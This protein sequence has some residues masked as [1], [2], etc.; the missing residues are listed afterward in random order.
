MYNALL[1]ATNCLGGDASTQLTCL[2][3]RNAST[4]ISANVTTP[5]AAASAVQQAAYAQV[6]LLTSAG[7]HRLY[8]L[9]NLLMRI[10]VEPYLPVVGTGVVD[11]LFV[12]LVRNGTLPSRGIPLMIG[13]TQNEGV[14]FVD[15]VPALASPL[16][17]S[18]STLN[19]ILPNGFD[20]STVAAIQ[21]NLSAVS[22]TLL[23]ETGSDLLS[24]VRTEC[25][26]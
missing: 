16:P 13:N 9:S 26:R 6:Q 2:Q 4:F 1:N 5:V 25:L 18:N 23:I 21:S 8:G 12:N 20:P 11:G 22:A 10:T 3:S 14:L 24:S 7:M 15:S 19:F 17:F